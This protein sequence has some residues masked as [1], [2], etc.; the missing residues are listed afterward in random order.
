M[1]KTKTVKWGQ[2]APKSGW[3]HGLLLLKNNQR[4]QLAPKS[5]CGAAAPPQKK[6]ATKK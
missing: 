5:V 1:N 4:G 2:H 3:S 6:S